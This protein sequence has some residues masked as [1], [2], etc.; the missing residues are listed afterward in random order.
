MKK[1]PLLMMALVLTHIAIA[2]V[3][4]TV[5]KANISFQVKNMGI[6]TGGVVETIH[7]DINFNKDKPETSTIEA[8]ADAASINTDNE[9]RDNH[10][11]K[12]EYFDVAKYPKITM[13][14]TA[15]KHKSGNNY[16]AT[17]NVT[18][19][20]KTKTVDVP[21]TYTANG[22]S[23]TFKG[24]FK[25]KRTDFG[26]GNSSMVLADEVTITLEVQTTQ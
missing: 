1:L 26:I 16:L 7:A 6:N 10:L 17:F 5:T 22:A 3:K 14:S 24:S 18:I 4:H 8:T 21:F 23:A 20:D 15:I 13:K 19:K 2:Q 12:E 25:I 11:K 9:M